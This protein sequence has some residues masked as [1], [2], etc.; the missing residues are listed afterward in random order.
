MNELKEF[1]IDKIT[2]TKRE[3]EELFFND[4]SILETSDED[5]DDLM[6]HEGII[7]GLEIALNK[8]KE[9]ESKQ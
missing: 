4:K 3:H 1:L 6:L 7:E 9:L 5:M 8:L 2:K